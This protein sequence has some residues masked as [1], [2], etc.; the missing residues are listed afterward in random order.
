MH[1]NLQGQEF[2]QTPGAAN[3][4]LEGDNNTYYNNKQAHHRKTGTHSSKEAIL[5]GDAKDQP[6]H[7]SAQKSLDFGVLGTNYNIQRQDSE[8]SNKKR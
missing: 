1:L 4:P 5:L 3:K 6:A 8:K 2:S 7:K